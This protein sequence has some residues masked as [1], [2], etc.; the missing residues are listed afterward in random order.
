MLTEDANR[1]LTEVGPGTRMGALL[2]RYWMPIA[3]CTELDDHPVKAVRLLGAD[4]VLYKDGSGHYGLVDRHCAHR[5][6]DLSYRVVE[7][8]GLRC[9][10]HGWP[11]ERD[12]RGVGPPGDR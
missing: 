5:R 4:L 7:A 12:E 6:A 1:A 11:G 9:R 10:Y 8:S 2:R 3:A